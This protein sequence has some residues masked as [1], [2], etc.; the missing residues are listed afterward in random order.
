[1]ILE[2]FD[3]ILAWSES[4]AVEANR[5]LTRVESPGVFKRLASSILSTLRDVLPI[6]LVI[7]FFQL[8]V[9]RRPIANLGRVIWGLL[10]VLLGLACFLVGLEMAL[11][12]LGESMAQS[13]TSPRLLGV[14]NQIS[15]QD[16]IGQLPWWAFYWTYL[17]ALTIGIS[18]T[19][20][21]PSLLAVALKAQEVSGGAIRA[22][23]LRVAVSLG[24]GVGV[25]LGT[26]RIVEG[27]PLPY[28]ILASYVV[29]MIQTWFAPKSIISLAYDTGGVTTSTV[30]VPLLAALGLGLST[31]IPGRNPLVDG[32][33]LI[34][35]ASVFPIIAV[36]GYAQIEA[37]WPKYRQHQ[38]PRVPDQVVETLPQTVTVEA[39]G[40][41]P[42][43]T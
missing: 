13:L 37:V 1:M 31:Q 25:A 5:V 28:Y 40:Q 2:G 23:G 22:L 35:F 12:P 41:D 27:H 43:P 7:L 10:F 39:P 6:V 11:F 29:V 8:A 21:E 38:R 33:G 18:T 20:A 3:G 36:L 15:P 42:K 14:D 17:F 24:V 26:Y 34:A 4:L 32:F 30:T 16:G 9:L 19:F